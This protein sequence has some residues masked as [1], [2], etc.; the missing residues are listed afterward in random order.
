M[1]PMAGVQRYSYVFPATG[2]R[3]EYA[4]FVSSRVSKKKPGPLVIALHGLGGQP[5]MMIGL[6][7]EQ[8]ERHGYIVFA[9]MGYNPRGGYGAFPNGIGGPPDSQLS[10][11]SEQDVMNVLKLALAQFNIDMRRIY[12]LGHSM[13]G[14]G[15]LHLGIKYSGIWAAVGAT[16][17]APGSLM[18]SDLEK[19]RQLPFI[20]VHGDADPAVPVAVSRNWAAKLEELGMTYQYRE[21]R[22]AGHEDAILQGARLVFD[23]FD[24]HR[25]PAEAAIQGP[26]AGPPGLE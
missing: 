22:A 12:L 7:R 14:G 1:D 3:L 19:A 23:F 26:G 2:E 9:P 6:L 20:L 25:R 10:E 24:K 21:L 18:P 13:G 8:A 11:F 15:A 5:G 4:V 17:P 16:A